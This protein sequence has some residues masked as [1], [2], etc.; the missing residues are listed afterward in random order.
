[1]VESI[2]NLIDGTGSLAESVTANGESFSIA[3]YFAT[4]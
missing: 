4:K 1:L 3:N 2:Q